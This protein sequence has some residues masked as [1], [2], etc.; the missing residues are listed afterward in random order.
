[1]STSDPVGEDEMALFLLLGADGTKP[2]AGVH[3]AVL[4]PAAAQ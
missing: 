4:C 2:T 3:F 1:M